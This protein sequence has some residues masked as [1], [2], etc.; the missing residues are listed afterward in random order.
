MNTEKLVLAALKE[1]NPALHRQLERSG[2]LR[3][4]VSDLAG[5]ISDQRT[6][7]TME[8]ASKHGLQAAQKT[9][10]IKA[11]GIMNMADKLATE[12]V[13]AEMLDF[14]QDETSPPSRAETTA[15]A[16]TI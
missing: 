11:V 7:L 15:S 12:T 13:L 6:T 2:K 5:E 8:I 10:P 3:E 14:P 16:I 1:K 4:Y 9:D